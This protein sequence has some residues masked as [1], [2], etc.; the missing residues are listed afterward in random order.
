M[1]KKMFEQ[2]YENNFKKVCH[3]W[4]SNPQPSYPLDHGSTFLSRVWGAIKLT[5]I[6]WR[7]QKKKIGT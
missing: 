5:L 4:D 3:K 7:P 6:D 1:D 2:K